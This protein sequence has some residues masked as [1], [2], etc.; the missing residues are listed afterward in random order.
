MCVQKLI[1]AL[2]FSYEYGGDIGDK[3]KSVY[4]LAELVVHVEIVVQGSVVEGSMTR[5][6]RALRMM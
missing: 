4:R 1:D 5:F 3:N 2:L 6:S